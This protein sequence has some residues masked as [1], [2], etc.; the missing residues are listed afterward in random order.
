MSKALEPSRIITKSIL[1]TYPLAWKVFGNSA[2]ILSPIALLICKCDK[3]RAENVTLFMK[4]MCVW[5]F[6]VKM[7]ARIIL[8]LP[9]CLMLDHGSLMYYHQIL[10]IYIY[11]L[12]ILLCPVKYIF[13]KIRI[14]YLWERPQGGITTRIHI[15]RPHRHKPIYYIVVVSIYSTKNEGK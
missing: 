8:I 7:G 14:F 10:Y 4:A 5:S 12:C 9:R 13:S 6:V 3:R 11:I 2:R 1:R 15:W